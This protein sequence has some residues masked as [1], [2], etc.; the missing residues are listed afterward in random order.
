VSS[1]R[2]YVASGAGQWAA[3]AAILLVFIGLAWAQRV[4]SITTESDDA[5]YVLLSR[6]LR[7]GGFRSIHLVNAPVHTKYPPVFPALLAAVASVAGEST[8]AFA[9]MN[10]GLTVLALAFIFAAARHHWP[11]PVALGAL[12]IAASSPALQT[13]AGAVASEPAFLAFT[14]L[15]LWLLARAPLTTGRVAGACACA[16]LAALTRTVGGTLILAVI[17]LLLLERRWRL[18]AVFTAI[19]GAIVLGAAFWLREHA[20]PGPAA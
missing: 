2:A 14:A 7:D 4:P 16:S 1:V 5:M 3:A 9:A 12:A 18:T 19:V 6:S 13:I 11:L 8:D 20:M 17:G 15:T 10:I